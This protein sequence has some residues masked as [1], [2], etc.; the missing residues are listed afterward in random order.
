MPHMY[1]PL[2]IEVR[3]RRLG[4]F[5]ATDDLLE[6]LIPVVRA[7][8]VG[9]DQMPFDDPMSLYEDCPRR[10]WKWLRGVWAGRARVDPQRW[11]LY[12]VVV[13]DGRP[14]GMQDL[15]GTDFAAFGTVS[16]FSWLEPGCGTVV[17]GPR[18]ARRYCTPPSPAWALARH[19]ARRSRTMTR[20]TASPVPWATSRTARRGRPAGVTRRRCC[21][22][23]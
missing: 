20:R 3:T 21:A 5:G 17:S 12:F 1:P 4:L 13:V 9:P 14:V 6:R 18:C 7:G 11:R 16:T 19:P 8:V 22:G 23:S 15:T 2:S 10:E